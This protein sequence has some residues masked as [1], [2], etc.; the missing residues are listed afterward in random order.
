MFPN[1]QSVIHN[2][3]ADKADAKSSGDKRTFAQNTL[4]D[5]TIP[6]PKGVEKAAI[7]TDGSATGCGL[8]NRLNHGET[9]V[10]NGMLHMISISSE[11]VALAA[12]STSLGTGMVLSSGV[13]WANALS[14]EHLHEHC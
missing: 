14:P 10:L 8:S 2:S 6:L 12:F 7:A 4:G 1:V 3:R 9:T 5:S 11:A 13:F